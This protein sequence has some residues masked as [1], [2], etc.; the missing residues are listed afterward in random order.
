MAAK[1]GKQTYDNVDPSFISPDI[2]EASFLHMELQSP[3]LP[4]ENQFTEDTQVGVS[5]ASYI[6]NLHPRHAL[7][8]KELEKLISS[9]IP[10]CD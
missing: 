9:A 3:A 4:L 7:I 6:S 8:H 1:S 2:R 10:L 5:I